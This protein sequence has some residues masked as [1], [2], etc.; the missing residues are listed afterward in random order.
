MK[1]DESIINFAVYEDTTE[2]LG[3]A[4]VAL[5]EISRITAEIS[6]AGINGS[7][8]APVVG[9]FEAM[10]MT[11]NFKTPSKEQYSLF[12]NRV[13]TLDLRVAQQQ[14]DPAT[15]VI[16]TVAVKHVVGVTPVKLSPGKVAPSST[17]DGSGEFSVSYFA[18]Y[19]DGTKVTEIDLLNFICIV[20]GIDELADVR[21][22][23]GK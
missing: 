22:A 16:N 9:H 2:F 19:I 1:V 21:T 8:N 10:S 5:P 23:L 20:N 6:G 3:M 12:E 11:L 17:A 7:Y 4:E 15:G 14:R 18:T 13:H